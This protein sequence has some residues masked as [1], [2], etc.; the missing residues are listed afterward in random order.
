MYIY[1]RTIYLFMFKDW[2]YCGHGKILQSPECRAIGRKPNP[3]PTG[4]GFRL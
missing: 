4:F 3:T 2:N 1:T